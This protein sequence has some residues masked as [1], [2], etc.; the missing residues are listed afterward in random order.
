[1]SSS[2]APIGIGKRDAASASATSTASLVG[3]VR[4]D[5]RSDDNAAVFSARGRSPSPMSSI[6]RE[7]A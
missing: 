5:A 1:M 6:R 4:K 3:V 7:I 2:K